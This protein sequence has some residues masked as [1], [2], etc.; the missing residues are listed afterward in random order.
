M[1]RSNN[2]YVDSNAESDGTGTQKRPFRT[3]GEAM[4]SKPHKAAVYLIA[5][6]NY[7][8]YIGFPSGPSGKPKRRGRPPKV[9]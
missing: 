8:S 7:E 5:P 4:A 2:V 1:S 3:M 9:K 6:G